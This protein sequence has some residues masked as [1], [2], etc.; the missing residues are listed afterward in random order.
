MY[1]VD[2]DVNK[3]LS[4]EPHTYDFISQLEPR[5]GVVEHMMDDKDSGN[6]ISIITNCRKM[7][8]ACLSKKV[9][10]TLVLEDHLDV[11]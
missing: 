3:L 1:T 10:I 11:Q 7:I 5:V 2:I 9:V 6:V 8:K 4:M